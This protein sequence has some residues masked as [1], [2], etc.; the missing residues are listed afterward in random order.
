MPFVSSEYDNPRAE[1]V[2]NVLSLPEMSGGDN[3]TTKL[4]GKIKNNFL[5]IDLKHL[6]NLIFLRCFLFNTKLII[7]CDVNGRKKLKVK[8]Y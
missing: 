6:Q 5:N 7:K 8:S 2:K 4:C 3:G 1:G